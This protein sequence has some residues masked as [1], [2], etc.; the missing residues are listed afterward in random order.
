MRQ[1]LDLWNE[2]SDFSEASSHQSL[3]SLESR[4]LQLIV[5]LGGRDEVHDERDHCRQVGAHPL[6]CLPAGGRGGEG[7][8]RG[9]GEGLRR[10]KAIFGA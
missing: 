6:A 1:L 8:G 5:S 10:V 7:G 9:G 4:F 3:E 2:R